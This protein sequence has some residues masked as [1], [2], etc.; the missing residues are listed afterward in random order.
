MTSYRKEDGERVAALLAENNIAVELNRRYPPE[1]LDFLEMARDAGCYFALG[2]DAHNL[3]EIGRTEQL[4]KIASSY[5]LPLL[6]LE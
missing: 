2:T 6:Q 3:N 4:L 5:D 1:H